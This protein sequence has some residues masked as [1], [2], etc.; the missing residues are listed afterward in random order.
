MIHVRG[1]DVKMIEKKHRYNKDF[2]KPITE[3][4]AEPEVKEEKAVAPKKPKKIQKRTKTNSRLNVRRTPELAD[5][6]VTTLGNGVIVTVIKEEN[7]W[8]E[9]DKGFVMSK[10]LEDIK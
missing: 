7:G 6:I 5:N 3:E 1:K 2:K 8:T 4:V 9:I 10:Y